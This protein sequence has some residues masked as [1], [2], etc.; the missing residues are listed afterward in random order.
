MMCRDPRAV[1]EH[2]RLKEALASQSRVDPELGRGGFAAVFLAHDV[3][4]A[5][6]V[7]LKVLHP[8]IAATL[9]PE[10]FKQEIK[11]AARLQHPHILGVFDSGETNGQ[12]WF[13]MP[14]VEGETLRD[15]LVRDK[16]LPLEQAVRTIREVADALD[17]AHRHGVIHRDIKP[18]NILL[19]EG[20][21][22]VAD[23]GIA[24][25]LNQGAITATGMA[26]GTPAYMSPEQA[27]GTANVDARSDVYSLGCVFY[28]MLT[29]E[30]PF[31]GPTP[32]AILSRVLTEAPRAVRQ[33]RPGVPPAIDAAAARAIARVAADRFQTA[34]E[35]GAAVGQAE[36]A[37]RTADA[38][39]AQMPAAPLPARRR[40]RLT[41]A[42]AHAVA[43]A[44][45]A[46]L[47]IGMRPRV[48][49]PTSSKRLAVLP[50][51][52][53]GSAEDEYFADGIT[54]EVRG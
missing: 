33:T 27:S 47:W 40:A 23:F 14:F 44:I 7:A 31:T 13:T 9:G 16:Q 21:A 41:H 36:E 43:A 10:R 15:R 48:T 53:L 50:F 35:F 17:Y 29:G 22:L 30:P 54:D 49:E 25:A 11:L 18:E 51:E 24:R 38:I 37:R 52:N 6:P 45:T 3:R 34:G 20:H 28:E 42:A 2:T 1:P 19:T 32:Q 39:S 8:E 5:R 46:A 26:V 4:H 12:L